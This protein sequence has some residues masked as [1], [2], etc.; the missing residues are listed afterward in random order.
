MDSAANG[1]EGLEKLLAGW[2]DLVVTDRA[3]PEISGDQFTA[4]IMRHAPGKPV[5][6]LTGFGD[7]MLARGERPPG[8]TVLLSKPITRAYL[9]PAVLQATSAVRTAS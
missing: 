1:A 6:M 2:F 7:L 5:I 4:S 8:V 9:R 3:M